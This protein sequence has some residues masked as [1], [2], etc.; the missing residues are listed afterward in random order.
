MVGGHVNGLGLVRALVARGIRTAVVTTEPF[1]VAHRS[2]LIAAA[3]AAPDLGARPER[4]L[5][6]L[7]R[8]APA[9]AGSAVFPANDEALAAL[10]RH[11]ERLAS[12]YRVVAPPAEVVRPLLDKALMLAA[13]RDV[14]LD[15]PRCWGPAEEATA[16]RTDVVF[17]VVVKPDVGHAFRSRFGAKLF[18]ARDRSE[19]VA[20]VRRF[21]AAGMHGQVFD[22]V[23]GPDGEI[24]AYCTYVDA[25]GEPRG[26]LT[27]RKLRQSP[28]RFGVAR[29]AEVVP[30]P[31]GL[32]DATI[33]LLRRLGHRGIAAAEFKRDPRDGRFRFLEVNG[34]AVIYNRLLWRAGLDLAGLAWSDAVTGRAEDVRPNGWPGVWINLHADLL[35]SLLDRRREPIGLAEFLAPYRRPRIEAVWSAT[36]PV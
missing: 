26:G 16:A 3:D 5:E 36:D 22:F 33:A 25:R 29:V 14:G 18:A 27:I 4:L 35:Y 10:A 15:L 6:I 30:D 28:P 7:D 8:R 21:A 23:P 34:R 13:A 32:R 17:P 2:R 31:P 11:G 9:W 12:T 1:D 19:L 20:A 24:H